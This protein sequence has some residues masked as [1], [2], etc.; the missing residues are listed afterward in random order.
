[1]SKDVQIMQ[2]IIAGY[3]NNP[4]WDDAPLGSIKTLSNTHIGDAGQDFVEAWCGHVGLAWEGAGSRQHPWDARIDGITFEVKTATEDVHGNFQFNHIRHHR[5]YQA[6]LCVGVAPD[7]VLFDL[8]RKGAVVEGAAD[9]LVT[10][11]RG[12]SATWKLTK[13]R[14]DLYPMADFER[15]ISS[16]AAAITSSG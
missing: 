2:G 3:R 15:R 16:L 9:N 1:M 14:R 8:W 4:K 5:S 13:K 7:T 12:S 6:L 10:M 11:D